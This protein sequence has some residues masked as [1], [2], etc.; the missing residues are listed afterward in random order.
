MICPGNKIGT[1]II[2]T[3]REQ[4]G[5]GIDTRYIGRVATRMDEQ[6]V[7]QLWT[8]NVVITGSCELELAWHCRLADISHI[9]K[10]L[11][12][13]SFRRSS[14]ALARRNRDPTYSNGCVCLPPQPCSS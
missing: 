4:I 12:D 8:A 13:R 5:L 2:A 6:A 3:K 11:F 7:K 10:S 14:G 1:D 9:I